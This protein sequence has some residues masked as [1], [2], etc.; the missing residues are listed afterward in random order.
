M[1]EIAQDRLGLQSNA[2]DL[3][4]SMAPHS[5]G[6]ACRA[7]PLTSFAVRLLSSTQY[8]FGTVI[9]GTALSSTYTSAVFKR[10][11]NCDVTYNSVRLIL[12]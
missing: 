8:R 3:L 1:G 9:Y 10:W 6:L 7:M 4:C 5:T 2:F 11:R 12:W